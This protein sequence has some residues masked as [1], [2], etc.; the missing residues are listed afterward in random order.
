MMLLGLIFALVVQPT[1]TALY[2]RSAGCNLTLGLAIVDLDCACED[3]KALLLPDL[4]G[5]VPGFDTTTGDLNF[6]DE[7]SGGCFVNGGNVYFHT[8]ERGRAHGDS[9]YAWTDSHAALC[10]N[11]THPGILLECPVLAPPSLA[12]TV[13][14]DELVASLSP[15]GLTGGTGQLRVGASDNPSEHCRWNGE[16][17]VCSCIGCKECVV[18]NERFGDTFELEQHDDTVKASVQIYDIARDS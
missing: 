18:I 4:G 5:I 12:P 2:V 8:A 9:P 15:D 3:A 10:A 6:G 14:F 11:S 1:R 7:W 17:L 16:A 13:P